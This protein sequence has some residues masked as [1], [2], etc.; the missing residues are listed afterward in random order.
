MVTGRTGDRNALCALN[1]GADNYMVKPCS[2][3]ELLAR[4]R[5][6]LR[7]APSFPVESVHWREIAM[8]M[9]AFRVTRNGREIRLG[10]IEFRLLKLMMQNP[11]RVFSRQELIEG[12]F[13]R[14]RLC[15]TSQCVRT[16]ATLAQI[17]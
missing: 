4:I 5:A 11:K 12:V 17:H 6:L 10:P 8:D 9:A 7:R 1:A 15:A 14:G 16:C 13:G 2:V 3:A